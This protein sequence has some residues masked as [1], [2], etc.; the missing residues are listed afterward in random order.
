MVR[1]RGWQEAEMAEWVSRS[2]Y[3]L[4]DQRLSLKNSGECRDGP[5]G[6][7]RHS[8]CVEGNDWMG[9]GRR[10]KD[11]RGSTTTSTSVKLCWRG[12]TMKKDTRE[13][14]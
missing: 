14:K 5:P 2:T 8:T 4:V 6:R 7:I 9:P 1:Q 3:N 11:K 12:K 10:S 13:Q